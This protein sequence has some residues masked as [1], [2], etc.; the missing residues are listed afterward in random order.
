MFFDKIKEK[1]V[2]NKINLYFLKVSGIY[3]IINLKNSGFTLNILIYIVVT[4]QQLYFLCLVIYTYHKLRPNILFSIDIFTGF[5]PAISGYIQS[6]F[7]IYY[8]D[9]INKA[10]NIFKVNFLKS[11]KRERE[12]NKFYD[13][14]KSANWLV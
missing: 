5:I 3:G 9:K 10:F 14:V 12:K 13:A 2:S 11:C 1:Y 7:L 4:L 6:L 8:S